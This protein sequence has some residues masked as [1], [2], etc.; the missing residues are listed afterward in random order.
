[1]H[2]ELACTIGDLLIRRTHLAFEVPDHGARIAER[3][4]EVVG[5]ALA[6]SVERRAAEVRGFL[7]ELG[8]LFDV[9]P[10]PAVVI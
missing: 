5:P 8:R 1:V 6:W 3:V 2:A 10:E 4:A 7:E 9:E